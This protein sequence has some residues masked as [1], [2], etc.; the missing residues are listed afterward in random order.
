MLV[1]RR[2]QYFG[3]S[4]RVR[5]MPHLSRPV[6]ARQAL[7]PSSCVF[8]VILNVEAAFVS[9]HLSH[10][11]CFAPASK[12]KLA[13]SD[14]VLSHVVPSYDRNSELFLAALLV[15]IESGVC[16]PANKPSTKL[17]FASFTGTDPDEILDCIPPIHHFLLLVTSLPASHLPSLPLP[18]SP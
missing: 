13:V 5:D 12:R 1:A 10:D 3:I 14:V 8:L 17:E 2:T 9:R 16:I 4:F 7:W 6:L 18:C 11:I 15:Y